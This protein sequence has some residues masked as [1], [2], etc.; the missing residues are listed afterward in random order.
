MTVR[1]L[2][3]PVILIII[4]LVIF[5]NSG[6]L[7]RSHSQPLTKNVGFEGQVLSEIGN[8]PLK[9]IPAN[10]FPVGS[11]NWFVLPSGLDKG[12]KLFF[13]D[14]IIGKGEPKATV[15]FVHGNPESSYTY[16]H[17]REEIVKNTKKTTRIIAMDHIGYGL[18]DQASY[19][20]I[21][22]HHSNNLKQ[23]VSHLDLN[24]VTLVIHDWGGPIGVGAFIDTPERVENLVLMNTTIF[25]VPLE[26]ITYANEFPFT[27]LSWT[28]IGT[29]T[30]WKIWDHVTSMVMFSPSGQWNL[31]KH[32]ISHIGRTMTGQ[33]TTSEKVYRDAMSTK[34]NSLSSKRQVMQTKLWGHG[35]SYNDPT[36]GK[37]EN[38]EYYKNMQHKVPKYWGAEGQNIQVRAFFGMFDPLARSDVRQQWQDALPQLEGHVL[39]YDDYGHFIE[40]HKYI[41]IAAG[42]IDVSGLD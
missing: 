14:F 15:V 17:V 18:S 5:F 20:M 9:N 24:N 37:Q 25:P 39:T 4:L 34:E 32:W 29:H 6:S 23:L 11:E 28:F 31:T 16:R 22:V 12:K 40:E 30:P 26:G 36:H 42:I 13:Y 1:L 19:E 2:F 3:I 21:D 33:L 10:Y 35:Y 7:T 27:Y 8:S 41:E 38:Y